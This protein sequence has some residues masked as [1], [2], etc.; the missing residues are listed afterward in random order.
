[1]CQVFGRNSM[2][3]DSSVFKM[4]ILNRIPGYIPRRSTCIFRQTSVNLIAEGV[5]DQM[6]GVDLH[7]SSVLD[8]MTF[9]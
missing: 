1:M 6:N 2:F 4:S 9:L 7:R 5:F 8:H 3:I